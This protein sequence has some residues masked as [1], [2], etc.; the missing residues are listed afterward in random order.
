MV[1]AL[2]VLN[3]SIGPGLCRCQGVSMVTVFTIHFC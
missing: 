2:D 3:M 1:F